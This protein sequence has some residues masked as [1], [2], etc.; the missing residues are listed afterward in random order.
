MMAQ[1]RVH[2]DGIQQVTRW[3]II[4][5]RATWRNL[6]AVRQALQHANADADGDKTVFNIKELLTHA[7]FD[8][9]TWK[10]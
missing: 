5:R 10:S 7:A 1:A 4:T 6:R 2:G 9:G 8:P 3:D